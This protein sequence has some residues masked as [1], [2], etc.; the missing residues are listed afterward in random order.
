[1]GLLRS[2]APGRISVG[3]SLLS[4]AALTLVLGCQPGEVPAW[5]RGAELFEDPGLSSSRFNAYACSTC[6]AA[7]A[8]DTRMLPGASMVGVAQRPHY[9]GGA[10][11]E[12][13]EAV[14]TCFTR[15]MRAPEPLTRDAEDSR[16]LY[17]YLVHLSP[18][19]A[20][21]VPFTVV[22]QVEEVPRGD[23]ARGEAVW[24]GACQGCHGD[25]QSGAGR[26]SPDAVALGEV[27][28]RYPEEFPGVAP[29]LV[30]VE[31]VRHGRF[32]GIGGTMPLFSREAL[33]DEDLGAL[34]R[35]LGL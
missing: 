3:R 23:A 25:A 21:A 33:G 19:P 17:E 35:Y 5:Q 1:M 13:L 22:R 12:L 32:Y 15:F 18:E 16:A 8:D 29:A 28:P 7:R 31:K 30:V 34:L 2:T 26:I 14:N 6:H 4:A 24:R 27:L 20:E 9:W 11:R 10:E